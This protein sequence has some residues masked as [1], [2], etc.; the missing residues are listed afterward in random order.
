MTEL[1]KRMNIALVPL[2]F[3]FVGAGLGV[4]RTRMSTGYAAL[5]TLVTA[6]VYWEL[7]AICVGW[8]GNG[9]FHPALAMGLPNL[10]CLAL[11]LLTY[12]RATW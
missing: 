4:V 2:I 6:L 1:F 11:A 3:A 7:L 10:L 9:T 12:R 5:I 8:G